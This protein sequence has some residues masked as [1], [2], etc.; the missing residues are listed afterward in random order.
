MNIY[1]F[2]GTI[3]NGDSTKDFYFFVLNKNIKVL[4]AIPIQ[5]KGLLLYL[6][7]TISKTEFKER[8]YSFL[9]Y[10]DDIDIYIQ[11]FW[12]TH[13]SKVF[14]WYLNHHENT[15]IIIS[16]SPEFLLKPLEK[17]MEVN[18]VIASKVDKRTGKYDGLNCYG[19]EKVVRL[20][21]YFE[22]NNLDFDSIDEFYSDSKSDE[23]LAK[24]AKKSFLVKKSNIKV[25]KFH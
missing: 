10:I 16:A 19:E 18:F 25:W 20:K 8:F 1:D 13:S 6:S 22:Q 23:P 9:Q 11:E 3:Y 17:L 2:D 7:K 4:N 15:D 12:N 21:E 14:D 24:L 5:F